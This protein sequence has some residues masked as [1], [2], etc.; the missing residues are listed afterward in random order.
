[1]RLLILTIAYPPEIRSVSHLMHEFVEELKRRGHEIS[2]I[3]AF[4]PKNQANKI[5]KVVSCEDG[6]DVIRV[7]TV[8]LT[9]INYLVR[10]LSLLRLPFIFCHSAKKNIS[11]KIDIVIAYSPPLTLGLACVWLQKHFSAKSVLNVQDIFPQNAID[12]GILNNSIMIRFFERIER[13]IYKKIDMITVHSNGNKRFLIKNKQLLPEKIEVV[14]NWIDCDFFDKSAKSREFRRK[15]NVD[16][17]FVILFAGILGP[18]QGLDVIMDIAKK[19]EKRSMAHFLFVGDGTEKN[20]LMNRAKALKLSNIS[21]YPFINKK[22]YALLLKSVDVGLVCL[23]G[24]NK[25]P[26]VPG[27]LMGYMASKLPVLAVLNKESDGHEIIKKAGCGFS[28]MA[29]DI[30]GVINAIFILE[31]EDILREEM[32]RKAALFVKENFS[33]KGAVD[34]YEEIFKTINRRKNG[35][36]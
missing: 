32:G 27:K 6:V 16:S 17:R 14:H 33:Q 29:E 19:I 11:K 20:K 7:K 4:P 9:K 13:W 12:L 1:M 22:E 26:V 28:F 23:S 10:G 25:T 15:Y 21:F 36:I 3:T 31:K 24:Q 35:T 34:Q 2:V 8:F 5:Y 30:E 18:A